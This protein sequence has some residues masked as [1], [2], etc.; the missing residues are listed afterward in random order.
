V[1]NTC[2]GKLVQIL[3]RLLQRFRRVSFLS[4]AVRTFLISVF[5]FESFPLFR[6]ARRLV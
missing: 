2:S 5:T 6:S 4:L 3:Y 1:Q